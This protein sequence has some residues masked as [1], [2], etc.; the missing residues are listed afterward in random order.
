VPLRRQQNLD[1]LYFRDAGGLEAVPQNS[2]VNVI[3]HSNV[4][5]YVISLIS[6]AFFN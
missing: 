3:V 1:L 6:E 2:F 4:V 5:P